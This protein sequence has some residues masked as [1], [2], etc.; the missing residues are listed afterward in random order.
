MRFLGFPTMPEIGTF[1][2][3]AAEHLQFSFASRETFGFRKQNSKEQS[4]VPPR[5]KEAS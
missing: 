2:S 5:E 4:R 3:D 1:P